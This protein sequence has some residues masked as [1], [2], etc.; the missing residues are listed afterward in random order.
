[1]KVSVQLRWSSSSHNLIKLYFQ[2]KRFVGRLHWWIDDV[3]PFLRTYV[4]ALISANEP[5]TT[6]V[7][8]AVEAIMTDPLC[9]PMAVKG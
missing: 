6:S 5:E 9:E 2:R 4:R 3:K 1:M 8:V 7:I